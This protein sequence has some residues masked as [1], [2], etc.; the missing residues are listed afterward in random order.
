MRRKS[1]PDR[2]PVVES[3]ENRTL[4]SFVGLDV[5]ATVAGAAKGGGATAAPPIRLDLV[6]LH[7]LGHSLGLAHSNDTSSIMYAYYNANYNLNSFGSDSA[8]TTFQGLYAN[9]STSAW[10][11]SLDPAPGNGKV[12][13]T[14]SFVRD[15]AA[16]DQGRRSNT[17]ATF[18]AKFGAGNWQEI[19]TTQLGR[20]AAASSGH[21]GFQPV[22]ADGIENAVYA[23]NI[24]GASQNDSRFG[25]IRIATH[26]FDGA[27][28]VLAHAYYPPP[29]GNTAAGDAHFDAGENWVTAA[30]SAL[31]TSGGGTGAASGALVFSNEPLGFGALA[32]S[33]DDLL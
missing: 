7:E 30:S 5:A 20:W 26:K 18:D 27:G 13:I 1:E 23:F 2:K 10:K 15:G 4:F 8:V 16:M 12:D 28:K 22:D 29:N 24:S 19:F 25:D 21:V 3:L 6:A 14:Y 17:F 31:A 9:V 33:D 32:D 11:D